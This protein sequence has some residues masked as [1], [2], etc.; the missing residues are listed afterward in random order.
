MNVLKIFLNTLRNMLN[1][2]YEHI[3][4]FNI[5]I[6]RLSFRP[7]LLASLSPSMRLA[8]SSRCLN[9][10]VFFVTLE[11]L[12]Y[13]SLGLSLLSVHSLFKLG[14]V[15]TLIFVDKDRCLLYYLQ[16]NIFNLVPKQGICPSNYMK[17]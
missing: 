1:Y 9:Y 17:A 11:G 7:T 13:I 4:N 8:S 10:K 14:Y 12:T 5:P 16:P 6:F 15:P 2:H 3:T